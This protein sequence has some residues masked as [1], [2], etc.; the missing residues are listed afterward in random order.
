MELQFCRGFKRGR[1]HFHIHFGSYPNLFQIR[2]MFP[3]W[4]WL[5]ITRADS[6]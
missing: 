5:T 2:I 1:G 3:L 6:R 4:P